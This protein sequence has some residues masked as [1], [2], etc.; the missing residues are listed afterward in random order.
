MLEHNRHHMSFHI[1]QVSLG[2]QLTNTKCHF[3]TQDRDYYLRYLHSCTENIMNES[4]EMH[5]ALEP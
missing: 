5:T 1:G 2:K 3:P 4:M